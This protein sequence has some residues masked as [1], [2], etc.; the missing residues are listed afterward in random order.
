[1]YHMD[2]ARISMQPLRSTIYINA[3][4]T[5]S[6]VLPIKKEREIPEKCYRSP[7]RLTSRHFIR[8]L[9]LVYIIAHNR[10]YAYVFSIERIY[11]QSIKSLCDFLHPLRVCISTYLFI[12]SIEHIFILY[13]NIRYKHLSTL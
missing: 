11:I 9:N 5:Q 1:M 13:V 10:T 6:H 3:L 7:D 4:H 8:R 12:Q 2:K